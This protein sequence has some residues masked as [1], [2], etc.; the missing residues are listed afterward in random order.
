MMSSAVHWL[1]SDQ[2]FTKQLQPTFPVP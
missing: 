2:H 1:H